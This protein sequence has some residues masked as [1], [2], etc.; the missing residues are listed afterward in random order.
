MQQ[1][2]TEQPAVQ[3][4][5][6]SPTVQLPTIRPAISLAPTAS[7]STGG[8]VATLTSAA[9]TTPMSISMPAVA[10]IATPGT[11]QLVQGQT[12]QIKVFYLPLFITH[13]KI[14]F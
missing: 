5:Q 4:A 8:S 1:A 13:M 6:P 2:Q 11:I 3:P 14:K 9:P 7:V 12:T 10:N